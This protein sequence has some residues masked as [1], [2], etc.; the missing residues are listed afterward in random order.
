MKRSIIIL[1]ILISNLIGTNPTF[2]EDWEAWNN[3]EDSDLRDYSDWN[4]YNWSSVLEQERN[5]KQYHLELNRT[6]QQNQMNQ[7]RFM[8][9]VIDRFT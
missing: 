8:D 9:S 6:L 3:Y 7:E 4:D 1:L 2:A 5:N